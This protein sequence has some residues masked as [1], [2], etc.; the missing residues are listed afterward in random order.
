M[1]TDV[2]VDTETSREREGGE[3]GGDTRTVKLFACF[4]VVVSVAAVVQL[5][6]QLVYRACTNWLLQ[7]R[8]RRKSV[9]ELRS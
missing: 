8:N 5:G 9:V 4:C 2:N 6:L 3:E 1:G 7:C